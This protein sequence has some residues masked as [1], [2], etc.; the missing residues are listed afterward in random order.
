MS[1]NFASI[2]NEEIQHIKYME[3]TI[4]E[5]RSKID[6]LEKS[7]VQVGIPGKEPRLAD[8]DFFNGNRSQTKIFLTQVNLVLAGNPSRFP[9]ELSKILYAASYMRGPAFSWIQPHVENLTKGV[10]D[11]FTQFSFSLLNQFGEK[12][13]KSYSERCLYELKQTK[14]VSFYATEF[15]KLSSSLCW[16]DAALCA[17]FYRGLKA[18]IKDQLAWIDRPTTLPS[19]ME[20]C[21]KLDNRFHERI[22]ERKS[23][24]FHK[25]HFSSDSSSK[26]SQQAVYDNQPTPMEIDSITEN[27]NFKKEPHKNDFI[28]LTHKEKERRKLNNLCTYCGSSEHQLFSCEILKRKNNLKGLASRN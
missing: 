2:S 23:D 27:R 7:R 25:P 22:L 6:N 24:I 13:E 9:T 5:L 10:M 8:P 1:R 18:S 16:N 11:S 12:D 21:I 20:L 3:E 15:L 4:L 17:H 19:L 28:K 26:Y 14:S